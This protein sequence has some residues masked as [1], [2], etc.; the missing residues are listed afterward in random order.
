MQRGLA[1]AFNCFDAYQLA[2]YDRAGAVRLRDALF[3]VH[4]SAKNAA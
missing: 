3:L 4:P 1:E 2:K